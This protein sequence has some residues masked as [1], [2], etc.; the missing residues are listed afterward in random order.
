MS[1][2]K[3]ATKSS[4]VLIILMLALAKNCFAISLEEYVS[5]PDA[6]FEYKLV[7]TA[8]TF[9][10]TTYIFEITSQEWHPDD[11]EPGKWKHWLRIIEPRLLGKYTEKIPFFSLVRSDKALLNLLR[12]DASHEDA[13]SGATFE[14]ALPALTSRSIVAELHGIPIGPVAFL[15]EQP[16]Q[17]TWDVM[18]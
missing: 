17:D 1:V 2:Q 13:P 10:Y 9:L 11:V 12:G 8:Y 7:K 5:A 16:D 6:A 14:E 18:I 4:I 15:D 3:R